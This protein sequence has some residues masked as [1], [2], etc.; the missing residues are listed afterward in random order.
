MGWNDLSIPKLQRLRRWSLGMDKP[1]HPTFYN[2]CNYLSM[3]GFKWFHV[4][5]RGTR[6]LSDSL[7]DHFM[8]TWAIPW[9]HRCLWS[10]RKE[11]CLMYRMNPAKTGKRSTPPP[12]PPPKQKKHKNKNMCIL[13]GIYSDCLSDLKWQGDTRNTTWRAFP[14]TKIFGLVLWSSTKYCSIRQYWW[15]IDIF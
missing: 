5:E 13:Y 3:L 8:G 10:N 9:L 12:P 2:V 15:S 6:L 7:Q 4:S 14:R 11:P 1:F